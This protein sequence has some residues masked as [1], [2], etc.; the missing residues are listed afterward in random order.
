MLKDERMTLIYSLVR[1]GKNVLDVGT[2]HAIIPIELVKNKISPRGT[3]TD[4]SRPS[5]DK[6]IKNI[7]AAGLGGKID[8]YCTDGTLGVP[9]ESVDDVIIAGMGGEL[10]VK[11]L[12]QD[13]RLR[14]ERLRFILQPMTKPEETRKFLY[15]NG[16]NVLSEEKVISEGRVYAVILAE[17]DGKRKDYSLTDLL[18]GTTPKRE[19]GADVIY[20]ERLLSVLNTRLSGLKRADKEDLD[21]IDKTE[22]EIE[23]VT[24]FLNGASHSDTPNGYHEPTVDQ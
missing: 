24:A 21:L 23:T 15:E 9:L 18:L 5:L 20:A 11:I 19:N 4:I 8:A 14:L 13:E 2:D 3:V 12:S 10:I 22:K 1:D 17:Y 6:G 7:A 16:F